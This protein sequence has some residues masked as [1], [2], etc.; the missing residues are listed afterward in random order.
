MRAEWKFIWRNTIL[1]FI[2]KKLTSAQII[3]EYSFG[4]GGSYVLFGSGADKFETLFEK[5]KHIHIEKSFMNS[6]SFMSSIAFAKFQDG[7][8]E[9][10]VHFEPYYL[11]DF[12]ATTP[13]QRL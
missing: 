10:A 4:D 5:H 13:K 7:A 3:N 12:V 6:A 11:K 9:D 2:L 8:V 1:I